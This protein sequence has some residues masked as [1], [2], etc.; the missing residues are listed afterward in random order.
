MRPSPSIWRGRVRHVLAYQVPVLL[1]IGVALLVPLAVAVVEAGGLPSRREWLGFLFPA[2]LAFILAAVIR[3]Q[4]PPPLSLSTT[5]ALL[6]TTASWLTISLIGAQPYI[7]V[8]DIPPID[9]LHEAVSGFTTAGTTMLVGLDQ[10]PRSIIVWRSITQWL[11]GMGILLIIL[12]VGRTG[13]NQAFSLL[14]AEGVKV[15]SGRLSLNFQQASRLFVAIYMTL[16]LAQIIL[17]W[18]LGMS[19]FDAVNHAM[20]TVSTGGFSP[21]DESIAYY[22]ARPLQFPYAAGLEVVLILFMLAGG[23]NFFVLY[24]LGRGNLSALWDGLEMRLLWLVFFVATLATAVSSWL[25]F[26]GQGTFGE[27]LLTSSF[28][29]ASLISTTG[30]EVFPTGAFPRFP[31]ELFLLLMIVG[32]CAGST[33]GGIKL[34]RVGI[35]S[36]FLVYEIRALRLP[37]HAV[38][39]PTVD[40][41]LIT[42][43]A[44][45]QA[46]FI[47]LLWLLYLGFGGWLVSLM[48]PDMNIAEAYSTVF[49]AIGVFGPSFVPVP[50]VIALPDPAKIIF[51]VGMLAG[52]LEILPL[53]VFFNVNG[54]R[55]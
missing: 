27:W 22:R 37:P 18:L 34:I 17:T 4:R 1:A 41:K 20:T 30:Y 24:R 55:K 47:L 26:A 29:I 35:L 49:S 7:L 51:I 16:T 38:H 36:K 50:V 25:T 6:V 53:L 46:A 10:M 42:D 21:H 14:S 45:R 54:W 9:A 39:S 33:A 12:L 28:E 32:G 2:V 43:R 48:A 15:S 13:G 40:G 31:R 3:F 52:R 19:L 8:L 44:F 11:G 5:E 23:I